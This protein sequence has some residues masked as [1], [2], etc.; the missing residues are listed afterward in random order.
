MGHEIADTVTVAEIAG[1]GHWIA[2]ESPTE[3]VASVLHFD[4][5]E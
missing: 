4:G 3:L 5:R 1:S 2:E